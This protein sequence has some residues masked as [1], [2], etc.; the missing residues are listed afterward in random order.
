MCIVAEEGESPEKA[1][2][3]LMDRLGEAKKLSTVAPSRPRRG[4]LGRLIKAF[5]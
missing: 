4:W 1:H 5:A 2:R 3:N